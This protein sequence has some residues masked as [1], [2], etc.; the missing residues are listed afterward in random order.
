MSPSVSNE[1]VVAFSQLNAQLS[2]LASQK[3]HLKMMVETTKKTIEEL[4][5]SE[6]KTAFKNLGFVLLKCDKA[7]LIKDLKSEIET[8]ELRTKTVEKSEELLTK[9]MDE[10]KSK[11]DVQMHKHSDAEEEHEHS[12]EEETK[13]E[14]S[15]K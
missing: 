14:K 2:N 1:D 8:L 4:E 3:S 11:L 13:K 9:K 10:L 15:K 6:E 7:K 12:H 5:Q